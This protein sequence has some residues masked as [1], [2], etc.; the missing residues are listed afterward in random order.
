MP[1][2]EKMNALKEKL[3]KCAGN[4]VEILSVET[5]LKDGAKATKMI[6]KEVASQRMHTMI[7]K[8][9]TDEAAARRRAAD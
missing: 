6:H 3:K 4:D 8:Q 1:Q 2:N 5:T 9:E 7:V